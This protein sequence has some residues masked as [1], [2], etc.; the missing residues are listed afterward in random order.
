VYKLG[1]SQIGVTLELLLT[2]WDASRRDAIS[3]QNQTAKSGQTALLISPSPNLCPPMS[4][5]LTRPDALSAAATSSS[6]PPSLKS[7]VQTRLAGN[8]RYVRSGSS[9]VIVDPETGQEL[10]RHAD[11][12]FKDGSVI[13]QAENTLYRVHVSQL[14]RH[15][16]LFRDIF[17]LPQ[18][19]RPRSRSLSSLDTLEIEECENCPVVVL[20]D[21]AEDVANFLGAL[22][23]GPYVHCTSLIYTL[24]L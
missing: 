1:N 10:H 14:S 18:P 16:A 2:R 23:D 6:Q 12:W 24:F 3:T 11:L 19:S 13:C 21:T 7:P 5:E 20:H 4:M 22:Y 17:T 15:S 8:F 9:T